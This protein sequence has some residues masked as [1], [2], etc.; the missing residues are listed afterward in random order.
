MINNIEEIKR[1]LYKFYDIDEEY[2]DDEKG[3]YLN[4]KWLSIKNILEVLEKEI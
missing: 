2:G 3:C 4:D 1:I